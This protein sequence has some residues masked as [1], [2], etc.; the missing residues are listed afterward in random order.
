VSEG[1]EGS[2]PPNPNSGSAVPAAELRA[3]YVRKRLMVVWSFAFALPLGLVIAAASPI[4]AVAEVFG[5][6]CG[7]ANAL[8]SM[9]GNERLADHRSV[10][11]FVL[12]SVLRILVF[13]IVPVEFG[14][15]GPWWSMATYFVGFFTPLALYA[16]IVARG[17]RTG[18]TF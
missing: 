1:E 11:S 7:V 14:L 2:P 18:P 13:G 3:Y 17:L 12:S 15:H 16:V 10:G 8:L 9:R 4:A 6:V 5:T